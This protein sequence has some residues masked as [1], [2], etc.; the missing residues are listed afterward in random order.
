MSPHLLR[1]VWHL[2][3]GKTFEKQPEVVALPELKPVIVSGAAGN[4]APQVNGIFDPTDEICN[5]WVRYK[6]RGG[7]DCWMEYMESKGQWHIKPAASKNSTNAW[8]YASC[9]CVVLYRVWLMC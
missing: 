8:A 2:Y 1:S 9:R 5:G 7:Q 6:K 4:V 3:D